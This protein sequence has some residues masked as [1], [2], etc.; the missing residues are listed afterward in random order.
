[1]QN[2]QSIPHLSGIDSTRAFLSEGYSFISR[3]CDQLGSDAFR[4]R[5]MLRPVTFLRGRDAVRSF[6]E[7]GR[8]TRR[9]AMPP[10]VVPLLQ[11]KGSVQSL[12][13]EA[14][15]IRKQM[16]LDL[17]DRD[18]LRAARRIFTEEWQAAARSWQGCE[19]D[20]SDAVDGI[21]TRAALRWCGIDPA[22]HDVASRAREL[23]T[24]FAAAGTLGPAYLQARWLRAR[25][26]RWARSLIS[27]TREADGPTGCTLAK[28]AFHTDLDGSRMSEDV[29]VKELLNILRPIVAVGRYVVF[30]AHALH[31]HRAAIPAVA[32][33]D[34]PTCRAIAEEVRRLYPFFPAIGG[35]VR[36]AFDWHGAR[37][38]PGDWLVL[39]LY[40]TNHDPDIWE[41]AER[42][43]AERHLGRDIQPEGLV[44]QGGGDYLQN[45]RCPG[46]WL[47]MELLTE[48]VMQLRKLDWTVP[49]QD[50]TLS[51]NQ[52]P[53]LPGDGLRI[54]VQPENP[55]ARC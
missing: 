5:L 24:M 34:E 46:E 23:S 13:D 38:E 55:G 3:R 9:G 41:D 19:I 33:D 51:D 11:G 22:Q 48:A 27:Q 6:Y 31:S 54:A 7:P 4:T 15:Q 28:L 25:C 12:D 21:M 29:A 42:F 43:R 35:R 45:H 10:T 20:F 49:E 17:M 14:H 36:E 53:P 30:A 2:S 18:R 52:F 47:T 16:F 32:E 40:G 44:P 37:F 1:M 26:E 50:L 8:M 39:D